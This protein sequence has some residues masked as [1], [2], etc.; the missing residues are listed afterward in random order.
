MQSI[1]GRTRKVDPRN[2]F[3]NGLPG[4]REGRTKVLERRDF[5]ERHTIQYDCATVQPEPSVM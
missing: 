1:E 3:I 5:L 4:R 2:D